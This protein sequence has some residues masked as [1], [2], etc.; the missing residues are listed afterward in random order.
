MGRIWRP[1]AQ[2]EREIALQTRRGTDIPNAQTQEV[3][4][5][6]LQRFQPMMHRF[7]FAT[8]RCPPTGIYNCHGMTFASRRTGIYEI[9]WLKTILTEDGWV[10]LPKDQVL[11]GDIILYINDGDIE[12]SGVVVSWPEPP[13]GIPMVYSKWGRASEMLHSATDCPYNSAALK[14]YRIKS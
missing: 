7:P 5:A 14:Y 13:L 11:P 1:G 10:E 4:Q 2:Q 9:S 8:F 3:S 6:E 12:H